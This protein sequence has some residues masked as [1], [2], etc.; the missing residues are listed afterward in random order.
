M[1]MNM[2]KFIVRT[3]R[4]SIASGGSS[5]TYNEPQNS[6]GNIG[7]SRE[8]RAQTKTKEL[9][10]KDIISDLTLHKSIS[11]YDSRIRDAVKR[12]Y[13]LKGPCQPISHDFP[14]SQFVNKLRCF[15]INWFKNC[16]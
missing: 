2:D 3:K 16:E 11:E 5:N 7:E 13:L 12:K 6:D 8:K 10:E 15:Q 14:Q 9:C 4:L 1:I